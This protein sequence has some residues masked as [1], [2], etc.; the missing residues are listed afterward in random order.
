MQK[1]DKREEVMGKPTTIPSAGSYRFRSEEG[2]A[3]VD[4]SWGGGGGTGEGSKGFRDG[5]MEGG[6]AI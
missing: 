6:G 2:N 4:R 5:W 3:K 1:K